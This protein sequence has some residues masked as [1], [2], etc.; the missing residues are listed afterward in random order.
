MVAVPDAVRGEA[1]KAIVT[2]KEGRAAKTADIIAHCRQR[3]GPSRSPVAI[4]QW[5]DLPKSPAGKIDTRLIRARLE[6]AT[7][8][9]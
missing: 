3:L 9:V 1:P 8:T 2:L 5:P 6:S 7:R 4:E